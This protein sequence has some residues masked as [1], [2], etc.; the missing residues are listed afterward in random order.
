MND[1]VITLILI[2]ICDLL[3]MNILLN[4]KCEFFIHMKKFICICS[5]GES[6]EGVV[7]WS[8]I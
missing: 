2:N 4:T 6:H 8:S 7:E 1:E 3:L 5:H